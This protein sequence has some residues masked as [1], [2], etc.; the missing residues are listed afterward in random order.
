MENLVGV[1]GITGLRQKKRP[2]KGG[3]QG[4]NKRIWRE[5]LFDDKSGYTFPEMKERNILRKVYSLYLS[6]HSISSIHHH[7][8]NEWSLNYTNKEINDIIDFCNEF[9]GI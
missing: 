6:G 7:C 2:L 9:N 1:A 4:M 8:W 5:G 3:I